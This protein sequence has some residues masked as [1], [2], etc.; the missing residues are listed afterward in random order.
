MGVGYKILEF[1]F[2]ELYNGKLSCE[3]FFLLL[4]MLVDG[5]FDLSNMFI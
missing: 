2:I 3:L 1:V 5:S 4:G